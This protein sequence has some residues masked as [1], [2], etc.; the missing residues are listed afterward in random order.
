LVGN[1]WRFEGG[2]S[3][4][5]KF[6]RSR[7]RPLRT[8]FARIDR[9]CSDNFVTDSMHTKKLCSTLSSSEVQFYTKKQPFCVFDL[10]L[11]A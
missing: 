1:Y 3:V 4:S 10:T 6:L 7:G 8:I 11:G 5:G 2:W 9:P